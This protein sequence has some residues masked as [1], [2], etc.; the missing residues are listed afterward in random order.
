[1]EVFRPKSAVVIEKEVNPPSKVLHIHLQSN[2]TPQMDLPAVIGFLKR[3]GKVQYVVVIANFR[4]LLAEMDNIYTATRIYQFS[5][6]GGISIANATYYIDYSRSQHI[7]REYTYRRIYP[8]HKGEKVLLATVHNPLLP[9][10]IE[11]LGSLLKPLECVRCVLFNNTGIQFLAEFATAE[12][13]EKVR[14]MLDG[15]EIY[16]DCCFLKV[17]YATNAKTLAVKYNNSKMRDFTRPDLPYGP[18]FEPG[19]RVRPRR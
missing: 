1:M 12:Q 9:I 8:I 17:V 16:Q 11:V 4:Q 15:R 19:S 18:P 3:F 6:G 14:D 13:A 5:H 7:N 2:S 10:T